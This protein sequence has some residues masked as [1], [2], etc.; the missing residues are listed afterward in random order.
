MGGWI[1]G[2]AGIRGRAQRTPFYKLVEVVAVQLVRKRRRRHR[3]LSRYLC[4]LLKKAIINI[5]RQGVHAMGHWTRP[6]HFLFHAGV[7][8]IR[9]VLLSANRARDRHNVPPEL[10]EKICSFFLRSDWEAEAPIA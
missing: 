7:H 6:R 5:F 9:V 8:H 10:W 3:I 2:Q 4:I 1:E